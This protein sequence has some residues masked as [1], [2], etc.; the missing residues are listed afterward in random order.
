[1]GSDPARGCGKTRSAAALK[2][3][4]FSVA[5]EKPNH[6][7]SGFSRAL[8]AGFAGASIPNAAIANLLTN[9]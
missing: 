6:I 8:G 5:P 7:N 1:M 2:G 3:R 9:L 4:D